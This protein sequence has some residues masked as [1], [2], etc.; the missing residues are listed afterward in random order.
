MKS[1]ESISSSDYLGLAISIYQDAIAMC[2]ANVSDLRDLETIRSR[3]KDEGL[4]FL[5]ITLPQYASDLDRSLEMG[6]ID[7]T[8]FRAFSKNGSIPAFLQGMIGLVFNRETGGINDVQDV[9]FSSDIP[10]V[11]DCIRQIC[12]AFKKL[13]L[14]CTPE[15]EFRALENYIAIESQ[16]EMFQV[17]REDSDS[18]DSVSSVLWDTAMGV[19]HPSMLVPRHGPGATAEH[20]SG[21]GKYVWRSWHERLEPFFP[22]IDTAYPLSCGDAYDLS[23]ELQL[24]TFHD[25]EHE[26]PVRVTPVPK[27]LKGPRIIAIEPCCMQYTQQGIR[28]AIYG[29]IESYWLTAGHVNFTDQSVNQSLAIKSSIDVQLA[30]IDLSDASD[31]VP[32]DLAMTMFK[33]NPD[34]LGSIEACR[35]T[36]AVMPDGRVIGPLRKFASMGSAL[37]F[38]VEAMY[39]YTI[40][41]LALL[42]KHN[43]PVSVRNCFN[44]SRHVYVYGDD[45]IVPTDAAEDVLEYLEKYNCKVNSNK[46]FYRGSFRESCGVDAFRG[47]QVTPV[48]LRKQI[49]KHM[50]QASQLI[51]WVK[52]ANLFFKKGYLRTSSLLFKRVEA[53]LGPLPTVSETS[54]GLG[55]NFPWPTKPRKRFNRKTQQLE[56]LLW[57]PRS[58]YRTDTIDGYAALQKSFLMMDSHKYRGLSSRNVLS[59]EHS[60]RHG[61]VALTRRWVSPTIG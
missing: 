31:R 56:E 12:L 10:C 15:R 40:C 23:K 60:A 21:N 2:S 27:T 59:F 8:F 3:V 5:T 4:S 18:F 55:R 6:F 14:P 51:S 54:S 61:D 16:F 30:T 13:E 22:F 50:Q 36:R 32:H 47:M 34:L 49:P 1:N 20:I 19:I 37:C 17:S 24:V 26:H 28:A 53:I 58:V 42:R 33:A 38:P 35:S 57:V 46:T 9:S 11:I 52:T 25:S 48:Y 29:R 41:V 45:L 44:V 43:L 39:F 7:P